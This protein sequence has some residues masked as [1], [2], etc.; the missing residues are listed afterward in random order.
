METIKN[1]IDLFLHVDKNLLALTQTYGT[2]SYGILA[3]VVFMET[4][5]VI[6][7]FLPGDSLLFA[8]GALA[9]R[10]A[11][12][13]V[14]LYILLFCA[15]LVG[16]N[17]NYWVGRFIGLKVFEANSKFLKRKHL[18]KT[19][20]FYDKHGGK[21]VILARF[22][23]IV[24]TFAPFVA[25]VGKM[26]YIK[27]LIFSLIGATLWVSSFLWGGYFLGNLPVIKENFHY[28]VLAIIFVSIMPI[29]WEV[30]KTRSSE[31]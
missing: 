30:V 20:K 10:G 21:A 15:V 28:M 19:Q 29:I 17:V 1:L 12:N 27:F 11:F 5:L 25:G 31:E 8:A 3:G 16:D 9:A 18:E 4:G 26:E 13:I 7:P 2:L 24:R 22:V 23:P 14:F 6:T